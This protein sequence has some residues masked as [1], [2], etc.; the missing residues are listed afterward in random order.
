MDYYIARQPIFNKERKVVGYELLY[1]EDG[2]N[3]YRG[4]DEN[5]STMA[6]IRNAMLSNFHSLTEGKRGMINFPPDLIVEKYP[7]LFSPENLVVDLLTPEQGGPEWEEAVLEMG[8]KGFVFS[9][10]AAVA[11]PLDSE[12]AQWQ[13][14]VKMVL[15]MD[16]LHTKPE[17]WMSLVRKGRG[18]GRQLMAKK[19]ET[20][21]DFD[22]ATRLGFD[23]YQGYFFS[24]PVMLSGKDIQTIRV[25]YFQ[26]LD[27]LAKESPDFKELTRI[28]EG[29]VGLS[30]KILKMINSVAYG[31]SS[32]IESIHQA[33]VRIGLEELRKWIIVL[34][35]KDL[36]DG[37]SDEL[38]HQSL[39]RANL[40]EAMAENLNMGAQKRIAFLTGLFS[41]LDVIMDRPMEEIIAD[42]SLKEEIKD[43]IMGRTRL[44]RDMLRS[45]RLYENGEWEDYKEQVL[46]L[47]PVMPEMALNYI[48][49][50]EWARELVEQ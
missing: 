26:I 21:E 43:A 10:D 44:Y 37:K 30:Y 14:Q 50:L 48:K 18:A 35:M 39:V 12:E 24:K 1:R 40:M 20:Q 49:A 29:D 2:E 34:M 7:L 45:I 15:Q 9:M 11:A 3:A 42:L 28:I 17:D 5:S 47:G 8:R 19:I 6:V 13:N 38:L 22:A 32:E 46:E 23:Y 4:Q 25:V 33:V 36:S 27:E 41:L 31:G 16:F